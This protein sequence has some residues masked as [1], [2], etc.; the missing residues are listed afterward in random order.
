MSDAGAPLR[1]LV[2]GTAGFIGSA[3]AHR[4]LSYEG[5]PHSFFDRAQAE[6]G[7]AAAQAWAE[8]LAFIGA[9]P[10]GRGS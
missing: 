9:G 5:A 4:L 3:V 7:A 8:V 2:T 1:I 6:H 10:A